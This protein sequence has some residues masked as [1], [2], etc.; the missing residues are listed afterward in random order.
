MH[1]KT[2]IRQRRISVAA[3]TIY[4]KLATDTASAAK[5]LNLP[6]KHPAE[7][8]GT[9]EHLLTIVPYDPEDTFEQVH[10]LTPQSARTFRDALGHWAIRA[11][12]EDRSAGQLA[13]DTTANVEQ[14]EAQKLL[15]SLSNQLA[16]PVIDIQAFA[17]ELAGKDEPEEEGGEFDRAAS[18]KAKAEEQGDFDKDFGLREPAAKKAAKKKAKRGFTFGRGKKR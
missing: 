13:L 12:K 16:L 9:A 4:K 10:E 8:A 14:Q 18:D 7:A 1:L 6:P 15:D 17:L 11:L 3:I 2:T 5:R